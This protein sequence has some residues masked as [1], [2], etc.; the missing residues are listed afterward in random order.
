MIYYY[1][2]YTNIMYMY[3]NNIITRV[4]YL[5]IYTFIVLPIVFSEVKYFITAHK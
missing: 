4:K 2:V 5:K 3:L 1:L